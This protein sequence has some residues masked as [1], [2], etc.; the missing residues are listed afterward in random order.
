MHRIAR[1]LAGSVA[2]TVT[3]GMLALAG[4]AGAATSLSVTLSS[5]GTGASAVWDA[6]G[7]PVLTVGSPSNSTNAEMT[8]NSP[9]STAPSTAPTFTTTNYASGSPHWFIQFAGGD[10]LYGF[11]ANAGLGTSNWEVIPASSGACHSMTHTPQFDTYVNVLAFIANAGCGGNVTA[12]GIIADGDQAAGTSDTITDILYDGETLVSG[13]D[14]VTV[15]NPGAQTGTVGTTIST[16]D[17]AASSNKGDHIGSYGATGLPAGLSVDATTG[18][19]TGT[20]TSAG[21]YSVTISATD[22]GGTTGTASFTWTIA[23]NT[24]HVINLAAHATF[25]SLQT[26]VTAASSGAGLL[27]SGTCTG[28]TTISS[29][30]TLTI[31]GI[32]R[33]PTLN[34]R[35]QGSVL[36]IDSDA[37]VTLNR[38]TITGGFAFFGGGIANSGSLTLNDSTVAGNT[39]SGTDNGGGGGI[40]N[41]RGTAT[42][43]NSRVTGNTVSGG[44]GG[45]GILN[46]QA[47]MVLNGFTT[48]SRNTVSGNQGGGGI[49]N[50]GTLTLNDSATVIGNSAGSQGG[51]IFNGG[52]LTLSGRA[53]VIRN[54]AGSQGGGIYNDEFST[55]TL[56]NHA[57]VIFNTAQGGADSGGGIYNN[58]GMLTRAVPGFLGN[59]FGNK[60]D[61]IGP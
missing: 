8:I 15:T 60:P 34:G 2:L 56:S 29:G 57:T 55:V 1:L 45:G 9:P 52:T 24:C 30:R 16:L 20:P 7:D 38:L 40:F 18:A 12:A 25:T 10:S 11:P 53:T 43:T 23:R 44:G 47:T 14:V 3:G 59:V 42:L 5:S 21:T 61:N 36:T 50:S 26:A 19:I 6:S 28:I 39:V 32:G 51:G 54:K 35:G 33:S 48:V 31:T 49:F 37:T 17:I 58:S 13:A 27:V 46:A 22:N 4:T 41:F